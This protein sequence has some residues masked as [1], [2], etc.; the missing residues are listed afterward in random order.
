M[1]RFIDVYATIAD[2]VIGKGD[3]LGPTKSVEGEEADLGGVFAE[4]LLIHF[5]PSK[6]LS[7]LDDYLLGFDAMG[8]GALDD[9]LGEGFAKEGLDDGKRRG[10]GLGWER[11]NQGL[12]LGAL[13]L[14]H[15]DIPEARCDMAAIHRAVGD[16]RFVT[17]RKVADRLRGELVEFQFFRLLRRLARG[18]EVMGEMM[19]DFGHDRS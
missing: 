5:V 13:D 18:R 14:G 15:L 11:L 3:G 4:A 17:D 12:D 2:I 9:F 16:Q 10:R 19:T 6:E 8:W 7:G 1:D